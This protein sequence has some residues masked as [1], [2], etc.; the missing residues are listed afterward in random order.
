MA[1]SSKSSNKALLS[2]NSSFVAPRN[3]EKR[4]E[5]RIP[6]F[7][8][9]GLDGLCHSGLGR[10]K[11]RSFYSDE[12][13]TS[14]GDVER[15][16]E[17]LALVSERELRARI[18]SIR[19]QVRRKS[20]QWPDYVKEALPLVAE[21]ARRSL[22][23]TAYRTQLMGAMAVGSGALVEMATGEGKTLTISLAAAIA[24]F[25][26]MPCHVITANDYLARRDAADFA[27]FYEYCGL[28]VASIQA[29]QKLPERKEVYSTDV[30]YCTGKE[31]V[32]DYLRD[33]ILLGSLADGKRRAMSAL[34]G[35]RIWQDHIV[36]RGLSI[37]IVDEADNQLIDEAVTPLIISR[38]QENEAM[39]DACLSV[40]GCSASLIPWDHYEIDE[41]YKEV[42]LLEPGKALVEK[43]CEGKIGLL[44]APS[45]VSDL[46]LQSLQARHFFLK[47]KQYVM[48]DG[49]VIIVD[50]FTGRPMP[51][52]NWRLGLHQAVEAKEGCEVS[53]P[54]ETLA[55]LSF[56]NFYRYFSHLSGITGTGHEARLEFWRVYELPYVRIPYYRP[57]LRQDLDA[58]YCVKET[59][60]WDAILQ[61]IINCNKSGRPVLIGTR[62]VDSSEMLGRLLEQHN[63][64]CKI[65]NAVRHNQEAEIILRAGDA[66][67]ITIA[68]NMAGRGSD[69]RISKKVESLGGLHVILTEGHGSRRIDRQLRGR[70]G[71]QGGRGSSRLFASFDDELYQRH[72]NKALRVCL[73]QWIRLGLPGREL[74]FALGFSLGQR[75]AEHKS[76]SQRFLLLKQEREIA[77]SVIGGS[78]KS[79]ALRSED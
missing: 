28:K 69:I 53:A 4:T 20:G 8:S 21:A 78:S 38:Q 9:S 73:N 71:R 17:Q 10:W 22:G 40:E 76:Q 18:R 49:K 68:T 75:R 23:L 72:L 54:S 31:L 37:A 74:L 70:A 39:R 63:L 67:A 52:R 6:E 43:W 62:S 27:T 60:K 2:R 3:E 32:A 35:R 58:V 48:D 11:S 19:S 36:L 25:S 47:D 46:V 66:G 45:W 26:G 33:Q 57:N 41:R 30:V 65:L 14:S 15:V 56:Q 16:R 12:L 44:S 59:E 34:L 5:I 51:G 79:A 64:G 77:K 29:D 1:K 42:H 24:G 55:K 61:E 50:E 7:I 13:W